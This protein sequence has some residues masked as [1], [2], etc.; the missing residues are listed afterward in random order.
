MSTPHPTPSTWWSR[1]YTPLVR[2]RPYP[3]VT[4]T[5]GG[6]EGRD[7]TSDEDPN[8]YRY[9][10]TSP[11]SSGH[12]TTHRLD[13][14]V[15]GRG[16]RV[17]PPSWCGTSDRSRERESRTHPCSGATRYPGRAPPARLETSDLSPS[18][19]S[20]GPVSTRVR[21]GVAGES[22]VSRRPGSGSAGCR[23]GGPGGRGGT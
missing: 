16:V 6:P 11:P 10:T 3:S 14:M 8:G 2:Y 1:L 22:W 20:P 13:P 21:A 23:V 12:E 9:L 17:G 5:T 19:T 18:E 4:G 15:A 7:L